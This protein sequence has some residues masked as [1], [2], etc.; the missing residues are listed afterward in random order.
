MTCIP[1]LFTSC[2]FAVFFVIIARCGEKVN[3]ND[4]DLASTASARTWITLS[5]ML[6]RKG[7]NFRESK[8]PIFTRRKPCYEINQKNNINECMFRKLCVNNLH[9]KEPKE[10][11]CCCWHVEIAEHLRSFS[12]WIHSVM[13]DCA[14]CSMN[15]NQ[16]TW[17]IHKLILCESHFDRPLFKC[18]PFLTTWWL[19]HIWSHPE[20]V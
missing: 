20:A 5:G 4:V 12:A 6:G 2:D 14:Q 9:Q 8:G 18:W 11:A 1:S 10:H 16:S 3:Q 13:V 17:R 15:S 7:A 19:S